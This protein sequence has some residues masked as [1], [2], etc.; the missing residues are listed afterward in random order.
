ML[1]DNC[2]SA[3]INLLHRTDRN[4]HMVREISRIGIP[5]KRFAAIDTNFRNFHPFEFDPQKV[6]KMLIRTPGAIGCHYSQVSLMKVA[7]TTGLHAFVMEDDLVFCSDFLKRMEYIENFL[8]GKKWDIIW[9]GGTFHINPAV[10]HTGRNPELRGS[11]I[12]RDAECTEDP[13]ILRTYGAWSTYAYIVNHK[14]ILKILDLLDAHISESMGIDWLMIKIQPQLM[15]YA[16]V[17]G[18]VKQMDNESDIGKGIT[19]FSRF[20]TLGPYWWQDR[21]EDF[22]ASAFNWAEAKSH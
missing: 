13:R 6:R 4:E 18:C 17:P 2:Y 3:Y 5:A 10:W 11:A 22:N 12:G 1:L 19:Y 8:I 14:S 20:S 15:T 7:E 21:M 16:F 9:L